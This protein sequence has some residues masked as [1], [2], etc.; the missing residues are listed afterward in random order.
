MS[1]RE[2]LFL[3]VVFCIIM[4]IVNPKE[5]DTDSD[6]PTYAFVTGKQLTA[7]ETNKITQYLAATYNLVVDKIGTKKYVDEFTET[8]TQMLNTY[9]PWGSNEIKVMGYD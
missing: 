5:K 3:W 4:S 6:I 2:M 8:E 9:S 1:I 7:S